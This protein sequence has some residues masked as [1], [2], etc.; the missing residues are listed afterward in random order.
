[1]HWVRS[2]A[3]AAV[4]KKPLPSSP[5][6]VSWR[7][8]RPTSGTSY[9]P[10]SLPTR[11]WD[12]PSCTTF[13]PREFPREKHSHANF[14]AVF[15]CT[16]MWTLNNTFVWVLSPIV[17][18][19]CNVLPRFSTRDSFSG[20]LSALH[21]LCDAQTPTNISNVE[22]I[23]HFSCAKPLLVSEQQIRMWTQP[24]LRFRR[25][26]GIYNRPYFTMLECKSLKFNAFRPWICAMGVWSGLA[27]SRVIASLTRRLFHL[28]LQLTHI[29]IKLIFDRLP[30]QLPPFI[31]QPF[32]KIRWLEVV[33]LHL[34]TLFLTPLSTSL[35]FETCL[36]LITPPL[37][38]WKPS[39]QLLIVTAGAAGQPSRSWECK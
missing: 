27:V 25:G 10:H 34:L 3:Q 15:L 2:S 7:Q 23:F 1:M 31:W 30:R 22:S 13:T 8:T 37:S 14:A 28:I 19:K 16:Q 39:C 29:A 32:C 18:W 38:S 4:C 17:K 20:D 5:S 33:A 24:L 6:V 11:E 26:K 21:T 12:F 35:D 36:S 9:Y